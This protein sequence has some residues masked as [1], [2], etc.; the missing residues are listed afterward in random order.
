MSLFV[1]CVC[2]GPVRVILPGLLGITALVCLC[3]GCAKGVI[4]RGWDSMEVCE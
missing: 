4:K 3:A 2:Q 1:C